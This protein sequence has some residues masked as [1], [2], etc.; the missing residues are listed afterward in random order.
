MNES[1]QP[2]RPARKAEMY[3]TV[4]PCG[5]E[6]ETLAADVDAT[7]VVTCKCGRSGRVEWKAARAA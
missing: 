3:L 1:P 5:L 2:I 6:S 7:G 4:C